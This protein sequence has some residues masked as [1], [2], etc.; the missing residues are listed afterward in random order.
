MSLLK[1]DYLR[2]HHNHYQ[3][4]DTKCERD[5]SDLELRIGTDR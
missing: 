2:N 1:R 3:D 5:L 4:N